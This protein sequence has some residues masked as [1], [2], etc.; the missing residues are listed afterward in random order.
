MADFPDFRGG[1]R[2][3][4]SVTSA[5]AALTPDKRLRLL[6]ESGIDVRPQSAPLE[7]HLSPR[8]PYA[9]SSAYLF[10]QGE[11]EFNASG[12]SLFIR[13]RGYV[14]SPRVV[15][16]GL[17]DWEWASGGPQPD[18]PGFVGVLVRMDPRSRYLADFSVS[19]N[20]ANIYQMTVSGADGSGTF[21][22]DAGGQHILLGLEA[23][24]G[25]Y[26]RINL[27]AQGSFTFHN[28]VVTKL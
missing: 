25:G 13:M 12:N 26:V 23:T 3:G 6:K 16:P 18:P 10:F 9:S 2:A 1:R 28:V 21:N 11:T 19:A 24:E 4:A 20:A 22:Q 5:P 7:F 27:S 14:P 8:E 15:V 17:G